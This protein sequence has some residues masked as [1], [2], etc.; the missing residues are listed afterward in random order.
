MT[1]PLSFLQNPIHCA[2]TILREEGV[3]GMWS[4]AT[5]TMMRNGTNQMC[6]FWAKHNMDRWG[7]GEEGGGGGV[8][9][10]VRG[11]SSQ[12]CGRRLSGDRQPVSIPV[13]HLMIG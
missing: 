5:P 12:A 7:R 9:A 2:V 8:R 13:T 10:W 6:L 1:P 3:R 11:G 4:G